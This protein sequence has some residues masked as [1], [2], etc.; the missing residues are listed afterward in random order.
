[1]DQNSFDRGKLL[2]HEFYVDYFRQCRDLLLISTEHNLRYLLL[3]E[4]KLV[5]VEGR[6]LR[7]FIVSVGIYSYFSVACDLARVFWHTCGVNF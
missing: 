2:C 7:L 6:V 1:M 4:Y 5:S 3:F